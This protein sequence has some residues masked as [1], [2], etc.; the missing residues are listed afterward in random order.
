VNESDMTPEE[1]IA[2]AEAEEV[3]AMRDIL[4]AEARSAVA[5][6]QIMESLVEADQA[7]NNVV[8]GLSGQGPL[9]SSSVAVAIKELIKTFGKDVATDLIKEGLK[10]VKDKLTSTSE[11][12]QGRAETTG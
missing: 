4:K 5:E 7:M 1:R 2:L 12:Q 9:H 10:W 11:N 6:A 3:E 8:M